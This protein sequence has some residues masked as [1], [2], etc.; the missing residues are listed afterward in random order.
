M[1]TAPPP[2][3]QV[4]LNERGIGFRPL[5]HDETRGVRIPVDEAEETALASRGMG[6]GDD[7]ELLIWKKVGCVFLG[8]YSA[9]QM[10]SHGEDVVRPTYPAYLVQVL[11]DPVPGFPGI[12]VAAVIVDARSGKL[13]TTFGAAPHGGVLGTTCG[14]SP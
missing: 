14:E 3:I 6:Y 10:P 2:W 12:N 8:W 1:A 13:G 9:P 7:G 4:S 11:A 5:T